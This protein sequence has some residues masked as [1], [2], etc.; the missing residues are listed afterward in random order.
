MKHCKII[1]LTGQTG[2]G[3]TT[4]LRCWQQK[5]VCVFDS[6]LAVRRIYDSGSPCLK[7]VAAQFGAD[8][9]NDDQSLNRPLLAQRA[10]ATPENTRILNELVHPF[11]LAQMLKV[12]KRERPGIM[13]CDAPQLFESDLDVLCDVIVSVL[14]HEE[15]RIGRI[16]KRDGITREQAQARV[17]AQLD[18]AFFRAHSDYVLENNG[19]QAELLHKAEEI[20]QVII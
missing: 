15:T 1:G 13:V 20:A 11:V 16:C 7:A 2:A 6:D 17:S 3:K 19:S 14:A 9:L 5:G 8:I 18:E 4:V 10:F 12:I